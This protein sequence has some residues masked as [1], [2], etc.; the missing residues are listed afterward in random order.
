MVPCLFLVMW[1]SHSERPQHLGDLS[2]PRTP[3]SHA[4]RNYQRQHNLS[5]AS[6]ETVKYNMAGLGELGPGESPPQTQ[7]YGEGKLQAEKTELRDRGK[8]SQDLRFESVREL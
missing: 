6:E 3:Q 4:R 5:L 7:N 2:E 8:Y 1:S